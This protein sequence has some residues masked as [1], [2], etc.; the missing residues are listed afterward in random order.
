MML[1]PDDILRLHNSRRADLAKFRTTPR[2]REAA[3]SNGDW[4]RPGW[5][6]GAVSSPT[7]TS[8][9]TRRIL[10]R[11]PAGRHIIG[12]RIGIGGILMINRVLP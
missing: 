8:A 11:P 1:H 4:R 9:D 5:G 10:S 12:D 7:T 3:R 2:A 6:A